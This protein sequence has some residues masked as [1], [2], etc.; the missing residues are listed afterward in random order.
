MKFLMLVSLKR[1]IK[2]VFVGSCMKLL[3]E[4]KRRKRLEARRVQVMK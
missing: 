2:G 4:K 1:S 3:S